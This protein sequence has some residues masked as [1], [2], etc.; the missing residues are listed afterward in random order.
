MR[1]IKLPGTTD[2]VLRSSTNVLASLLFP[3]SLRSR[4]HWRF[5]TPSTVA[6]SLQIQED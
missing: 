6:L 3:K 5:T 2:I 4:W 1:A